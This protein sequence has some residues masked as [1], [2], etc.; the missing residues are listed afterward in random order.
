MLRKFF[1]PETVYLNIR[2]IPIGKM[3]GL[4]FYKTGII[5][6]VLFQ[7]VNRIG[8]LENVQHSAVR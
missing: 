5:H 7:L 8:V 2:G 1:G 3:R 4:F 6:P